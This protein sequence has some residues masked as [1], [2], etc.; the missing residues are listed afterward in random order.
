MVLRVVGTGNTRKGIQY[1]MSRRTTLP[2]PEF[3]PV[4][5]NTL[6]LGDNA[7]VWL[8]L[9]HL[10]S[11]AFYSGPGLQNSS[12]YTKVWVCSNGFLC[13]EG[14]YTNPTPPSTVPDSQSPN[15]FIAP[16]W[17]DLDPTGG[18]ISWGTFSYIGVEYLAVGWYNVLDRANYARQSFAVFIRHRSDNYPRYQ[19]EIT[20]QYYNVQCSSN[21]VFGIED[22]EGYKGTGGRFG[23]N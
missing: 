20:F 2:I 7:G 8:S 11:V 14:E 6:S 13:F 10:G 5:P 23:E 18:I 22:H 17:S 4:F 3:G 16:Y 12:L 1:D 19:N 9:S 15:T 21:A